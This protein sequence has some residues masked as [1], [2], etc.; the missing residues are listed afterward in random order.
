MDVTF[1]NDEDGASLRD[2]LSDSDGDP[3]TP[4]LEDTSLE[5]G[6][7]DALDRLSDRERFVVSKRFGIG[8]ER[9]H[10]L[11]EVAADLGVSL[12][13]VRQIQVRAITKMNTPKLRKQVDPFL[14]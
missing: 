2:V 10:T 5:N 1:G 13:R 4:E 9:E 6:I 12:E 14:N 7:H 11:A 3:Y 8:D